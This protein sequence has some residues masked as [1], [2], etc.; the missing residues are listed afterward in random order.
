MASHHAVRKLELDQILQQLAALCQYSVAAERALEIGPSGDPQQVRYLLDVTAE[1]VALSVQ[2]PDLTIGGARDIRQHIQR[3]EKGFRLQPADFLLV[4]DTLRAGRELR[5]LF[6]RLPDAHERYP[7]LSEFAESI[8]NFSPLE[9]DLG[10]SIGPR[11]D[12]LD[13]ASG[14]LARIRK[15]VRVA[16]SRLHDRL[17]SFL[18]G[19]YASALQENI[20]T[21]RDGRYVVPVRSDARGMI[22]G[23]VH[24]TS[25]SGQTVYI[26]PFEVVEL[27]NKWREEQAQEKRE[28]DRIL[29]ELSGKIGDQREALE[30]MVEAIAA[31]DL[32]LAKARLAD[33]MEATRPKVFPGRPGQRVRDDDPG[34]PSH[35]VRLVQARHPLIDRKAVVPIDLEIGEKFRVLL[36][37]GPNTGGKTV[38]LKTVGL[39]TLMAQTGLFIPADENS[40]VSVFPSVF[41]DIGD[42]Q[43]IEQSL[44]TFSSHIRNIISMLEHVGSDSLVLLDEVGAGTDPQEGSALARAIISALL[45]KRAIVIAT[46]HYSEVKAYAYATPGVENAS[47]EFDLKSL[48]PTYRLMIGIPGRSN[49]L[50]IAQRL[51]MPRSIVEEAGTLL[52]P[53]DED[54]QQLIDDIRTRRDD[55]TKELDRVRQTDE[56]AKELRRKA[57]RVL[58]EAEEIKRLARQEAIA[59]VEAELAEARDMVR[60]IERQRHRT[61][62]VDLPDRRELTQVIKA[63][64]ETVRTAERRKQPQR[65][66]V[67][68]ET[69]QIRKGDRVRILAF[70]E[71]GEVLSLDGTEA[72]IQMG[73][74]KIRQPIAG[75]ER[76]GRAKESKQRSS[77]SLAREM[78]ATMQAVPLELDLRGK[79]VEEI[80]TMVESY[81]NDAYMMGMPFVR[82]IHGKGT[83]A[84]R[85]VVRDLLRESPVVSKAE[86]AGSNEG[87]EGATVAHLR[88]Q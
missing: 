71:E 69:A 15:A 24:D 43:S 50:S 29:D 84:L 64:E 56:E 6:Q 23:L 20:I 35:Y 52:D 39:L 17:Q 49:A 41:V 76:I 58:R 27:N 5:K 66:A 60:E 14:E 19:R 25:A 28:V 83:G 44:S 21:M 68:V 86:A 55:I 67:Q 80:G 12:V 26:E 47:V 38:A 3:A 22:K 34:H 57:A 70:G 36:I 46:T 48:R 72:D 30:R 8:D 59:E 42:E 78:Q 63:A 11:G 33:R 18:S 45:R 87:G 73:S 82:I 40:V 1:A 7:H 2:F 62:S 88:Q 16:H 9:T 4:M 53:G 10:R 61:A 13:G 75:L 37:T 85:T 81:L 31:I 65:R 77:A 54:A 74:L 32:A 79:R 51:G